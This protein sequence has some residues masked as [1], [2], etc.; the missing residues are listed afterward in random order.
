MPSVSQAQDVA[1]HAASWVLPWQ[2]HTLAQ[3]AARFRG[4]ALL[5]HASPGVGSLEFAFAMAR[6]ELCE[7]EPHRLSHPGM[8]CGAC[9]SCRLAALDSHPD[10]QLL[11]PET[12]RL[13][14]GLPLETDDRR[15]PSRQIRI[16]EVRRAIDWAVGTPSRGRGKLLLIHPAEAMNA[17]S[18]SALLKTLEEPPGALRI[19]LTVSD[20]ARLMAT[21]L[22]RCQ[23][24]V[25][26]PPGQ[27]QALEWLQGQGL[28]NAAAAVLLRAT[29]GEPLEALNWH[30]GGVTPDAWSALPGAVAEDDATPLNGWPV[31]RAVFAL[32]RVCHDAAMRALGAPTRFFAAAAVPAGASLQ[33]LN[34]WHKSLIRV[35]G[36][37]E[38]PWNEPLLM[39]ALVTE[40][41]QA[42]AE[43]SRLKLDR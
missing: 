7:D 18:A 42:W 15:K 9:A 24:F 39:E 29:G 27:A 36:H 11:L 14:R 6:F 33:V 30:R 5:L 25:L 37:A 3:A 26:A 4:H 16:E 22:S 23:R 20:P 41:A 1:P 35:M 13:Q 40:G 43:G 10:L 2:S 38:H 21:V 34:T 19:V 17:A 12:L 8:A 28:D 31:H 32:Q